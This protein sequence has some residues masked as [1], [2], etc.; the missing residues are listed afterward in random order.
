MPRRNPKLEDW[1]IMDEQVNVKGYSEKEY[2]AYIQGCADTHTVVFDTI[3]T[4]REASNEVSEIFLNINMP[5]GSAEIA[6]KL[7]IIFSTLAVAE[8]KI[9]GN[10]FEHL[11]RKKA[12]RG[13][14]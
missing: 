11:D 6:E 8:E 2:E 4:L 9:Q 13:D 5:S 3:E 12:E 1:K 10:Y 14:Y 7:S